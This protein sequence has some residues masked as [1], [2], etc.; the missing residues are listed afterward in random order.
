MIFIG[1]IPISEPFLYFNG[2]WNAGFSTIF[3]PPGG[4]FLF[5][6]FMARESKERQLEIDLLY[7]KLDQFEVQN[8]ELS[9]TDLSEKKLEQV[10]KFIKE[11]YTHEIS[12]E[13]LA[14]AVD[15][16]PDYM[17]RLFKTYTGMKV[18]EYINKLRIEEAA[19][20][21]KNEKTRVIDI[22]FA[23]GFENTISFN[24]TFKA[25]NGLTP[26]EY[27]SKFTSQ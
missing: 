10:I 5:A 17:S 1:I 12:R 27:R 21:L 8:K 22:A 3:I 11:N 19:T 25:Q 20:R 6:F 2:Y 14:S 15:M 18:S 24:R 26:S 23:V 13:G 16:N 4:L 9:I 7:R